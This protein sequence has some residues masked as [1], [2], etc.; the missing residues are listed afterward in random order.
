MTEKKILETVTLTC[1]CGATVEY[2]NTQCGAINIGDFRRAT[3]WFSVYDSRMASIW[4]CPDCAA[5]AVNAANALIGVLGSKYVNL[6]SV[7]AI[8][9]PK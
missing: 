2:G 6:A 7:L 1:P 5:E 3:G 9:R 8:G 4:V